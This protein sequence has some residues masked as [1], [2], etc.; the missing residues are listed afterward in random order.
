MSLGTTGGSQ[1]GVRIQEGT[2]MRKSGRSVQHLDV[3]SADRHVIRR[4]STYNDGRSTPAFELHNVSMSWHQY[5]LQQGSQSRELCERRPEEIHTMVVRDQK[6]FVMMPKG[7]TSILTHNCYNTDGNIWW[8]H[9]PRTR[10]TTQH[11]RWQE[12]WPKA[13]QCIQHIQPYI[14]HRL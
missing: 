12:Q 5:S 10:D 3:A 1:K 6:V 14:R 4:C 11:N 9:G 8:K 13:L 7:F 2:R